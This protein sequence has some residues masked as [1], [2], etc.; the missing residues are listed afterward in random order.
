MELGNGLELDWSLIQ[1][2]KYPQKRIP[3][4]LMK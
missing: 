4:R 2:P 1:V 3:A